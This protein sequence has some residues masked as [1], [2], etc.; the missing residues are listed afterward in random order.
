MS[1]TNVP[2]RKAIGNGMIIGWMGW[3][4]IWAVLFGFDMMQPPRVES[5]RDNG[6]RY[7]SFPPSFGSVRTEARRGILEQ[8]LVDRRQQRHVRRADVNQRLHDVRMRRDA[9]CV[10]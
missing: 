1:E 6:R 9:R 2:T 8:H 5:P 10:V 3:P 7:L 4:K